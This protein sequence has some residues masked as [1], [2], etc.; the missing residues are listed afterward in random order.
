V[1]ALAHRK[2][3][4]DKQSDL[5]YL[6]N[7][8]SFSDVP[9]KAA[10]VMQEGL[11]SGVIEPTEKHWTVT[12]DNWYAAEEYDRALA[13]FQKAGE[14]ALDGKIDLRRGYILVDR[15]N[16]DGAAQALRSALDKGGLSDNQTGEA[17]LM[18]GMTEFNRGNYDQASTAWGRA[19]RYER[20]RKQAQQWMSHMRDERA[21]KSASL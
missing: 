10:K 5:L 16:W 4:L 12:G 19:G 2:G 20:T 8:Y 6:V 17:W 18:L 21:R 11:E 15:E 1:V 3:M 7:L 9:Y 14:A 13:A